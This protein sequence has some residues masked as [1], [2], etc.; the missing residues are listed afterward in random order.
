MKTMINHM[1]NLG[2]LIVALAISNVSSCAGT[3]VGNPTMTNLQFSSY[4]TQSTAL[5]LNTGVT[6]E[7]VWLVLSLAEL[8]QAELCNAMGDEQYLGPF[9]VEVVSGREYPTPI[10]TS[11]HRS[12]C[13]MRLDFVALGA[14]D[15]T[16]DIPRE[17]V[18]NTVF[19]K[20]TRGDGQPFTLS[21]AAQDQD[22]QFQALGAD[23]RLSDDE[24]NLFVGFDATT[25]FPDAMS[26]ERLNTTPVDELAITMETNIDLVSQFEFNFKHSAGLFDDVDDDAIL[27]EF[28]ILRPIAVVK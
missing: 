15:Q 11:I 8:R 14:A 1:R 9:I 21:F 12:F 23:F 10:L 18:G 5:K 6:I 17:L 26:I 27:N 2:L 19:V 7:E 13:Q 3:D 24:H 22:L 25:W 28:E 4:S 16:A 20:G